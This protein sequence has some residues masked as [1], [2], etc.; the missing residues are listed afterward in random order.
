MKFGPPKITSIKSKP[1]ASKSSKRPGI[2]KTSIAARRPSSKKTSPTT[3]PTSST[4]AKTSPSHKTTS[5][6]PSTSAT[7]TT[8]SRSSGLDWTILTKV[9]PR[10]SSTPTPQKTSTMPSRT[11][12]SGNRIGLNNVDVEI[13]V[14]V[15]TTN[16]KTNNTTSNVRSRSQDSALN[17]N[18]KTQ[19]RGSTHEDKSQVS[20]FVHQQ[21]GPASTPPPIAPASS[22]MQGG[23]SW[24]WLLVILVSSLAGIVS[25]IGCYFLY[26][27]CASCCGIST[28]QR[29]LLWD[30]LL[31][32]RKATKERLA[33]S[34][35]ATQIPNHRVKFELPELPP[36]IDRAFV[37]DQYC[38]GENYRRE[39][40]LPKLDKKK[41]KKTILSFA[42][43]NRP[44]NDTRVTPLNS[45]PSEITLSTQQLTALLTSLNSNFNN[46]RF[47]DVTNQF[48]NYNP[49]A[50]PLHPNPNTGNKSPTPPPRTTEAKALVHNQPNTVPPRDDA[51]KMPGGANDQTGLTL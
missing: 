29:A 45:T 25:L 15:K 40:Q 18:S 32:W 39:R 47:V 4:T 8:P 46:S 14:D 16:T 6:T 31:L 20:V 49:S 42:D 17:Q 2:T 24:Y 27:K 36:S 30:S 34:S 50:P 21:G 10:P 48:D 12:H 3:T 9:I 13:P 1:Q 33:K 7:T 41:T 37:Q 26:R 5:S 19:L 23:I 51:N 28:T 35:D 44:N 43:L 22:M 38:A 11:K